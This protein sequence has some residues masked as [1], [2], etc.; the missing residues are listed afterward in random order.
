MIES[1]RGANKKLSNLPFNFPL[2]KIKSNKDKGNFCLLTFAF[3][4]LLFAFFSIL[5]CLKSVHSPRPDALR[6]RRT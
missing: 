2:G 1:A 4:L 5:R 6:S 3:C